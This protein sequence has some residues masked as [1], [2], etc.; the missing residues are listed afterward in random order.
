MWRRGNGES[1][2]TQICANCRYFVPHE[3]GPYCEGSDRARRG[4]CHRYPP[5]YD[6]KYVG[7]FPTVLGRQWCGEF[8]NKK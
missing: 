1:T 2:M 8:K 7:G 5:A 6:D 3:D 4:N